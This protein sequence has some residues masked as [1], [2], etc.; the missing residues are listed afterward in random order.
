MTSPSDF[1]L[2][3]AASNAVIEVLKPLN[4][5]QR[6]SVLQ[7]VAHLI[8]EAEAL[9]PPTKSISVATDEEIPNLEEF[10]F[11]KRSEKE[12]ERVAVLAYYLDKYE[13][14]QM[15]KT[16]DLEELNR[17]A[18][19]L[20]FGNITKSVNNAALRNHFFSLAG[21]GYKRINLYGKQVV[22]ALPDRDKVKAV[23]EGN[24]PTKRKKRASKI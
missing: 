1:E 16:P 3:H 20:P 10:V 2:I 12:V 21:N 5:E 9:H 6:R 4:S 8:G 17:K 7:S 19:G 18:N 24:T 14:Q 23:I 15:F 13:K 11:S 22:E